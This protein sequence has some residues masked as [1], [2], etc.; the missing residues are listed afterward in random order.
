MKTRYKFQTA[1]ELQRI[2]QNLPYVGGKNTTF[3]FEN[4]NAKTSKE[5]VGNHYGIQT[6]GSS[7]LAGT[8]KKL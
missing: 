4:T 1:E 7:C 5:N 8:A 2:T 3:F 6:E